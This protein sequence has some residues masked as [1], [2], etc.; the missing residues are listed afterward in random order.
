[1]RMN[2]FGCI[3]VALLLILLLFSGL[4]VAAAVI[5]SAYVEDVSLPTRIIVR[6][7]KPAFFAATAT[8]YVI[9]PGRPQ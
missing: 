6:P 3:A 1:M 7:T 8:P 4:R 9:S 5:E 2:A